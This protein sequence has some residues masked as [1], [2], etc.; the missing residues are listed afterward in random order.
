MREITR[1]LAL[2]RPSVQSKI[3]TPVSTTNRLG[4]VVI[5]SHFLLFKVTLPDSLQ[6][7]TG[8]GFTARV[9]MLVSSENRTFQCYRFKFSIKGNS[10]RKS[11]FRELEDSIDKL[12]KLLKVSDKSRQRSQLFSQRSA[13]SLGAAA[14]PELISFWKHADKFFH[15]LASSWNCRCK[16]HTANLLL[17]HRTSSIPEFEVLLTRQ[18]RIHP[19]TIWKIRN[20]KI[21]AVEQ[22]DVDAGKKSVNMSGTA[23]IHAPA[24]RDSHPLK[25]ALG[26]S[27]ASRTKTTMFRE[28]Q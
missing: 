24:H 4:P 7:A 28:V 18:L 8:F 3:S 21:V 13:S 6:G 1:Q 22:A 15:V 23:P 9:R 25:S 19:S 20:T 27:G 11:L 10:S 12:E 14:E 2:D 5:S 26:K 17:Q 16:A